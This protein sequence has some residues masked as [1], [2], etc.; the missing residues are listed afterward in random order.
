MT[1]YVV[2]TF[3]APVTVACTAVGAYLS[4]DE[5]GPFPVFF[6]V[7]ALFAGAAIAL[8]GWVLRRLTLWVLASAV[9]RDDGF[10]PVDVTGHGSMT[11]E[12][13]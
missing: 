4:I 2:G 1:Y 13:R 3:A 12:T 8:A 5:P 6:T 10:E 9:S 11:R 7:C